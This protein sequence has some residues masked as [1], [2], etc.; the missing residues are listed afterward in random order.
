MAVGTGADTSKV[1]PY[2]KENLGIYNFTLSAEEMQSLGEISLEL[3]E[4]DNK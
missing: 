4:G 3:V 1:G 2:A